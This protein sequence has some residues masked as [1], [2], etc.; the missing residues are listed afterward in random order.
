M[1]SA[2]A[3]LRLPTAEGLRSD[4]DGPPPPFGEAFTAHMV[5]SQWSPETGWT[6]PVLGD[7]RPLLI[8]PAMVALHYGQIVIEGLK[9]HRRADGSIVLFRADRHAAR[10]RDSA[11]RMAMPELP[12]E[13]FLAA[14]TQL[15]DA[16]RDQLPAGPD[17][18]LY[19]RPIQFASEPHLALRPSRH[20][21]FL[22]LAFVTGGFFSDRPD[23]IA[24]TTSDS[25]I[26]AAPGGTGAAKC[27]GNYAPT[28]LAQLDAAA[29][30]YQ[31]VLWLDA[32]EHSR[33]EELGG[34]NI[35]F[36]RGAGDRPTVLTPPLT[37]T[38]LPGVTRSSIVD[39]AGRAGYLVREEPVTVEQWRRQCLDGGITEAFACGTAAVVTPIGKVRAGGHEWT[40][41]D[42]A[43][44][45]VT[46]ALRTA[47]R[48]IQL[49]LVPDPFGWL[50]EVR[51]TAP[52]PI[53]VRSA[54]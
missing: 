44:G 31:Q 8:D 49:G 20:Y 5:T 9:A 36:V 30:G 2:A 3:P 46:L 37:G 42:G 45:P 33:V 54:H 48:E 23:P 51:P 26:R 12:D 40:V 39:L 32:I 35:F 24:V 15:V 6:A 50:H 17:V 53:P 14:A 25:Y 16:D 41:G 18:S 29:D 28:Y 27:A 34:M 13:V 43:A 22:L 10:L 11:R 7:R 19:L 21:T 38:L 4:V 1:S 52:S 47:L